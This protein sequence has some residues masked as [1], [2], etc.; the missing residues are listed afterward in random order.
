MAQ[1][2][3]QR[4]KKIVTSEHSV[5]IILVFMLSVTHKR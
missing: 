2:E 4:N 5:R 1:V 3:W